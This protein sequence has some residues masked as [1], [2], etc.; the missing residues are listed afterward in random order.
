VPIQF[1]SGYAPDH[2]VGV[3]GVTTGLLTRMPFTFM[4]LLAFSA[5]VAN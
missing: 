1:N 5:W 2:A 3:V 4:A